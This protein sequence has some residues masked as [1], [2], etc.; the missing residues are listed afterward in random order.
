MT[1]IKEAAKNK[2]NLI[3]LPDTYISAFPVWSS[4]LAPTQNHDMFKRMGFA[5]IYADGEEI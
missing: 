3:V 5:Y 1:F 4:I 2:A